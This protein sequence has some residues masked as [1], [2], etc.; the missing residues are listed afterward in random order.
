MKV[1]IVIVF[2]PRHDLICMEAQPTT[3]TYY[4]DKRFKMPYAQGD[5]KIIVEEGEDA[6]Q[7]LELFVQK[8]VIQTK[9]KFQNAHGLKYYEV[10]L[11]VS[12]CGE[13]ILIKNP[14][15]PIK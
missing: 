9:D 14:A 13:Y 11:P 12:D 5:N 8:P 3:S 7:I 4:K 10:E 6:L 2:D 15:K 1:N